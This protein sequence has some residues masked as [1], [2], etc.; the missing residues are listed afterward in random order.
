[1]S[2]LTSCLAT[3]FVPG[4]EMEFFEAGACSRTVLNVMCFCPYAADDR[5]G[6]A[7]LAKFFEEFGFK[8]VGDVDELGVKCGKWVNQ[9]I[10]K[11]RTHRYMDPATAYM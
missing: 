2:A 3:D 5:F 7:R 1:M 11:L 10:F 6:I 8:K 9:A 4:A